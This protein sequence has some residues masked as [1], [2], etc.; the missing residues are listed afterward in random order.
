MYNFIKNNSNQ[1]SKQMENT[2]FNFVYFN[3]DE[4]SQVVKEVFTEFMTNLEE[5][6]LD[7]GKLEGIISQEE[8]MKMLGRKTTWFHNKRIS[9]ELPAIKSANKW[10]YKKSIIQKFIENGRKSM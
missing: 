10:W 8:A 3:K 1:K 7:K 2:D 5:A 4:L 9:G 6:P